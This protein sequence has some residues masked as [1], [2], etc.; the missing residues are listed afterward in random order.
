MSEHTVQLIGD[1]S[2]CQAQVVATSAGP[3]RC[4]ISFSYREKC[5]EGSGIDY[6]AALQQIRLQLASEGLKPRCY[7][8]S[9][10]V[11]PS[12]MCRSM[13]L[14][15]LGYRLKIG[16]TTTRDD[17]VRIFDDGPDVNPVSVEEQRQFFEAWGKSLAA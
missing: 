8:A 14:G 9:L 6:F 16:A 3:D 7:G 1:G 15:M 2:G 5:V 12:G 4:D 11:W 13:G 10:N 17:L